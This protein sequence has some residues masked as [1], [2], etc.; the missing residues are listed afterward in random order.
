MNNI[1]K[2]LF[3]ISI[4]S[5][6]AFSQNNTNINE[7][8]DIKKL[9]PSKIV[10][11]HKVEDTKNIKDLII[12]KSID[13]QHKLISNHL[14]SEL[15]VLTKAIAK[16]INTEKESFNI[17][18]FL[19]KLATLI[20]TLVG[21]YVTYKGLMQ[22]S[23]FEKYK[24]EISFLISISV[25]LVI[26]YLLSNVLTSILYIIIAILV[27]LIALVIASAFLIKFIDDS[28]PEIKE[29]IIEFF[30]KGS[31]N[32]SLRKSS[33][34]NIKLLE[35]WLI[36]LTMIQKF[37]GSTK[38]Q[39]EGSFIHGYNQTIF[40]IIADES[41]QPH[42]KNINNSM[43]IPIKIKVTIIDTATNKN[44]TIVNIQ[45]GM[46]VINDNSNI[47]FKKLDISGYQ[48]IGQS[49]TVFLADKMKEMLE[50]QTKFNDNL[51][52]YS[53]QIKL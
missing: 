8:A 49:L 52:L 24:K 13:N 1:I 36:N 46:I 43:L 16:S 22:L 45:D 37:H 31:V 33:R 3:L 5:I 20:A 47:E 29:N 28:Y 6:S 12:E 39:L 44:S 21:I 32:T 2:L 38:L 4:L 42:W 19:T 48:T 7:N 41:L 23:F 11:N 40:E 18:D 34:K 17:L 26:L 50:E 53:S 27:L 35:E 30:S 9:N 25:I 10:T 14:E 15:I 51:E